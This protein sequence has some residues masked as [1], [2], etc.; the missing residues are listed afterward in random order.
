MIGATSDATSISNLSAKPGSKDTPP[1]RYI[2][3]KIIN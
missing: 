3:L 1:A 2:F